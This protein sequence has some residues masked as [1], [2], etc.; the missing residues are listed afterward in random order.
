M[1][2]AKSQQAEP[3][4]VQDE[5]PHQSHPP[6]GSDGCPG[7]EDIVEPEPLGFSARQLQLS[8]ASREI[9]PSGGDAALFKRLIS[10]DVLRGITMAAMVFVDMV[11]EAYPQIGHSPWNQVHLADFVMPFFLV[12]CGVSTS[13]AL[14]SLGDDRAAIMRK[15]LWRCCMLF[16]VG[17]LIQGPWFWTLDLSSFRIMGILQRIAIA[18]GTAALIK[19]FVPTWPLHS[20]EQ[21][22]PEGGKFLDM[23]MFKRYALQWSSA[24]LLLVLYI[25]I[26]HGVA[27]PRNGCY[28]ADWMNGLDYKC[29]VAGW[30]DT[31][32]LSSAHMYKKDPKDESLGFDPEGLATTLGCIFTVYVGVHVGHAHLLIGVHHPWRCIRHWLSLACALLVLAFALVAAI[33]FN[34]RMWSVSYNFLMSGSACLFLTSLR[35]LELVAVGSPSSAQVQPHSSGDLA[36]TAAG[37]FGTILTP[38]RWLGTNALLFFVFSSSG[39]VLELLVSSVYVKHPGNNFISWFQGTVLIEWFGFHCPGWTKAK[40]SCKGH[41]CD[42]VLCYSAIEICFW[43]CICGILFRKRIFWKL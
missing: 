30:I 2:I 1:S 28:P 31:S 39:G 37:I 15:L 32:I 9:L 10:I 7:C 34:K 13:L 35:A 4:V 14:K 22:P 3:L 11:G 29:N 23:W 38:F 16:L 26:M 24:I 12:T 6:N 17:I 19:V 33:P 36:K 18:Y 27:V 21:I 25:A 40:R 5:D 20:Q 41:G 43:A 42:M 8:Q